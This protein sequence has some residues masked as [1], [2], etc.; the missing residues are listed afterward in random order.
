MAFS[1]LMV[2]CILLQIYGKTTR[3]CPLA[4][5]K[6]IISWSSEKSWYTN[7]GNQVGKHGNAYVPL[8]GPSFFQAELMSSRKKDSIFDLHTID[9]KNECSQE[10]DVR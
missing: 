9:N 10:V 4:S 3:V 6:N 7:A 2:T 5:N 1:G 8:T